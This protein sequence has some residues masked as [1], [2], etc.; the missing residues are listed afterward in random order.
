MLVNLV[1]M[2]ARG[3]IRNS[4]LQRGFL[5]SNSPRVGG[6]APSNSPCSASLS[7]VGGPSSSSGVGLVGTLSLPRPTLS[8]RKDGAGV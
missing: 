4:F 1:S 8:I 5:N 6:F 2:S 3:V 7:I